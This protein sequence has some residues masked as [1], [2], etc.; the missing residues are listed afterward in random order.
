MLQGD[1]DIGADFVVSRDGFEQAPRNFIGIRVQ[2]TNPAQRL[3][4][5][6]FFEQEREA[7]LEAE[8]F[9]VAGRVLSDERNLTD[10]GARQALG[11]GNHRFKATRAE[12]A[13]QL[14]NDAEAAR[15]IATLRNFDVGGVARRGQ[16]TRRGFV[17][18]IIW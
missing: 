8:I 11:L 9:S 2:E 17:V 1:V 14:W 10:P 13:A 16:N 5:S 18:E 12:L 3:D 6:Q 7:V 4:A 15:M